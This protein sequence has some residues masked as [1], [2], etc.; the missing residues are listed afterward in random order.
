MR[1]S[2]V[3]ALTCII[4]FFVLAT[5]EFAGGERIPREHSGYRITIFVDRVDSLHW[6]A[7]ID[8][9]NIGLIA[10]MTLPFRW[11]DGRSPFRL[12]SADYRG[13]RTEYFA[14]KT[15]RVDSTRQSVLIGMISDLGGNYPP[16]EPGSGTIARLHFSTTRPTRELPS[17]DTAFIAPH[18]ILQLVTPDVRAIRPDFQPVGIDGS[19]R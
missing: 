14:L 6:E 15:F 2:K 12:D 9:S 17:L 19:E 3:F 11:G 10:A 16:L 8:L 13:L 18:N 5:M 1:T 7:S 4:C